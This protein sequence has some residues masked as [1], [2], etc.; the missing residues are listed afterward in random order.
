MFFFES[1]FCTHTFQK[2]INK[3]NWIAFGLHATTLSRR[4]GANR[5]VLIDNGNGFVKTVQCFVVSSFKIDQYKIWNADC[6]LWAGYKTRT[7]V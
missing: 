6:G 2:F 5:Q 4:H 1:L 7:E 3:L